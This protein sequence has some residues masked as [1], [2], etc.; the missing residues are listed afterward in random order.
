M[1]GLEFENMLYREG[2]HFIVGID[3]VGRGPLA[4]PLV[5]AGVILPPGYDNPKIHDSKQLSD[6]KRRE[7]FHEIKSIALEIAYKVIDVE[8]IDRLNIYQA[9]KKAMTDLTTEFSHPFDG[10]LT[11]AMPLNL[12]TRM[13]SIIHGDALSQSIAAASIVA[14][15]IRDDLMIEY[16][17][18]YPGYGFIQNK[19][20]GTKQHMKALESLGPTPIHRRTF[21]PVSAFFDKNLFS[22]KK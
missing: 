11:D 6:K 13:L 16:D 5:V 2:S 9:T 10:V 20:Y 7:L 14:K 19:G 21:A 4:G 22:L 17:A 15:V 1:A 3:E 12:S 18:R 8:E